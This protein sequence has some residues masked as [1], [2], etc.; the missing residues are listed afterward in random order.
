MKV[1]PVID[2][3]NHAVVHAVRGQRSQYK[4]LKSGICN[5]TEPMSVAATFR[6]CGFEELYIADL[7]AITGKGENFSILNEIAEKTGLLIMVDAGTR[8]VEEARR[9]FDNKVSK[10]IVGTETLVHSDFVKQLVDCF[11]NQKVTAS[12]DLK[13]GRICSNSKR[14]RSMEPLE[15][16][17]ELQS[18]GICE[19]IVLDLARVGSAEGVDF[20]QLK[21]LS[22]NLKIRVLVGGGISSLKELID[23]RDMGIFG[24]LLATA[25]HSGNLTAGDLRKAGLMPKTAFNE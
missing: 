23:L 24:V 2:I 8:D 7:D 17:L 6:A 19:L 1:I 20:I 21:E 25:L 22:D 18:L 13:D 15:L 9:L 16:A 10:V 4:S 3:L 12:L 14:L 5:S 11:G